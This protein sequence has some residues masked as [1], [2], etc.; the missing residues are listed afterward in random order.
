MRYFFTEQAAVP[1]VISGRTYNFTPTG[2]VSGRLVGV[3]EATTDQVL[4]DLLSVVGRGVVE[5]DV[6]D[7]EIEK[8]KLSPSTSAG[9]S[10]SSNRAAAPSALQSVSLQAKTGVLR[11]AGESPEPKADQP[12]PLPSIKDV[13][14]VAR[15]SPVQPLVKASD[16]TSK[17]SKIA[18]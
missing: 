3:L 8:K 1:F 2:V 18:A 12:K 17:E 5:I 11:A 13:I 9:S 15:V 14:V 10:P 7:F 6:K 4:A 16:R